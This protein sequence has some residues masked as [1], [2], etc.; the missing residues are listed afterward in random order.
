[1]IGWLTLLATAA[2][3]ALAGYVTGSRRAGLRGA[4][5]LD[6][7][8]NEFTRQMD[9]LRALQELGLL[10]SE[11]LQVGQIISRAVGF[12]H[13]TL[14]PRGTF[15]A[16]LGVDGPPLRVE[17]AEGNVAH[18]M[19]VAFDGSHPCALIAAMGNERMATIGEDGPETTELIPGLRARRGV[20]APLIA[21]GETLGAIVVVADPDLPV[22]HD[23]HH[24]L[25][26][27]ANHT[28]LVLANAR[29]FERMLEAKEQW[30]TTF[31][32]LNEGI[33][34]LDRQHRIQRANTALSSMLGSD[35]RSLA[36]RHLCDLLFE[37]SPGLHELLDSM[38][39][40]G[41]P[42]STTRRSDLL[43]RTLRI[44]ASPMRGGLNEEGWAAVLVEDVTEW[45]AMEARL[46]QNERMV[47][48]G[49]L[50]SGVAHELNN[51]LTSI[52]GLAEFLT[53]RNTLPSAEQEHLVVIR[54]QAERANK[55]VNNLLTFARRG[56]DEMVP[57]DFHDLARRVALLMTY[58]LKLQDITLE[59]ALEGP[60]PPIL[61]DRYQ[62]QQ[63]I[64][65][66]LT[67]AVQAVL[68]VSGR[69]GRTRRI[70]LSTGS[71]GDTVFLRVRDSGPG[72]PAA[73]LPHIFL[74]FFTT[75]D[76][77]RG[78]GLG[79]SISF[80]IVEGHGGRLWV[81]DTGPMGTTFRMDL[82]A[83]QGAASGETRHPASAPAIPENES[84]PVS[85]ILGHAP[86]RRILLVDADQ[87]VQRMIKTLFSA[88]GASVD[89]SSSATAAMKR[90]EE[91]G[92]DLVIA[93][94]RAAVSRGESLAEVLLRRWPE[95]ASKVIFVTADVRRET[96]TW[97]EGLGCRYFHKPFN[98]REL[99][100][101]AA[102]VFDGATR[103]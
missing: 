44:T 36:G 42:P 65:N 21:H 88:E 9:Q 28:A 41:E 27:A 81:E 100:S 56:P 48:V 49:Q 101:A 6:A 5:A 37:K 66:L 20:I 29:F 33:A 47:A 59:T 77:G 13:D 82:P 95:H 83:H 75:K 7:S 78:T 46:I 14:R 97:L 73:D 67:N 2:G 45:Q 74:P 68:H 34:V 3:A 19:G 22:P 25:A 52:S 16:L 58:D 57:L 38:P 43:D 62:L 89:A 98:V 23:H 15:A 4:R 60:V 69:D 39:L 1:V 87:A 40:T 72:V 86:G 51:P 24:I 50:V 30:E 91:V 55:I 76:P 26:A 32:A 17:A 12:V 90:L 10:L 79:L 99:L 103:A 61:G 11:S 63:V 53:S 18:L 8:T 94:P 80:R 70:A 85:G 35:G 92:Y 71:E 84:Q 64:V 102:Q 93:D 31:H 54:D 96:A